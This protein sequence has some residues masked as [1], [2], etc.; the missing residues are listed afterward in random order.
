[1]RI[2]RGLT[3][4]DHR[5]DH[6]GRITNGLTIRT[7]LGLPSEVSTEPACP[8]TRSN[9]SSSS[10]STTTNVLSVTRRNTTSTKGLTNALKELLNGA[11]I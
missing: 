4:T 10:T 3:C 11:T 1:M 6:A 5:T 8:T 7:L 2:N 9:R